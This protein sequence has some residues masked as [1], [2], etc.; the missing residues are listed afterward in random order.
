MKRLLAA[1]IFA[2]ACAVPAAA[3]TIENS[4]GNTLNVQPE[5]SPALRFHFNA[6]NTYA[7]VL[8]D[9]TSVT[10]TWAMTNGQ[11]CLTPAGGAA[12]C[13][14]DPGNYSVGQTWA[15]QSGQGVAM[16]MSLTAGR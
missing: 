13:H 10:G 3:G 4:F 15:G 1:V 9:N 6:D 2:A 16:Q 5:G 14:P 11:L 7:M 12:E 8:P